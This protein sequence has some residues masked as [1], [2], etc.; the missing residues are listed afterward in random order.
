MPSG[1]RKS[2]LLHQCLHAP[3]T[4]VPPSASLP[5]L[6]VSCTALLFA[7][8][9]LLC[10]A[11]PTPT[12][13]HHPPARCRGPPP[14]PRT[15]P[16]P[17]LQRRQ[18]GCLVV[19]APTANTVAAAEHGISLLCSL[20]RNVAQADAA[21]KKGRWDRNKYVGVSLTGKTL[22]IIGFGKVGSEVGRRAKGLGMTVVAYD[23]YA[24]KEKAAA[25]GVELV[26]FDE[27]LATGDFFS[28]HMPLTPATKNLFNDETFAKIKKGARIINVARGGVIDEDALLRA[29]ESKKV[30][31]AALD[32]LNDEPPNFASEWRA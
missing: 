12:N 6:E 10:V 17:S 22:A 11:L 24:S 27:A 32:V 23:P 14:S 3:R 15:P 31:A 9:P 30:A 18:C 29:L 16:P 25:V 26:S 13:P 1:G 19:N 7:V 2:A 5:W 20:A 21:I 28:L 8:P 4:H